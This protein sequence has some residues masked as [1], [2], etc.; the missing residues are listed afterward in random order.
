MILAINALYI[1]AVE[2]NIA[3]SAFTRNNW[4]LTMMNDDGRNIETI[5]AFTIAPLSI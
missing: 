5:P 1:T 3:D 2:K 4:F